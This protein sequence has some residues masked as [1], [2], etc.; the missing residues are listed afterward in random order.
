MQKTVNEI[1]SKAWQ[2]KKLEAGA[3]PAEHLSVGQVGVKVHSGDPMKSGQDTRVIFY[4][5]DKE[6]DQPV[7]LCTVL[8]EKNELADSDNGHYF[9]RNVKLDPKHFE[10]LYAYFMSALS[11]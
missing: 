3:I 4:F 9:Q 1:F 11:E 2:A 7:E 5:K 6:I 10:K 8:N